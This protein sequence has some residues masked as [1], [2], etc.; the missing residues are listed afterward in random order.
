MVY[1]YP[2]YLHILLHNT[3]RPRRACCPGSRAGIRTEQEWV[4]TGRDGTGRDGMGSDKKGG[5]CVFAYGV[6]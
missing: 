4:G 2:P 3:H 5:C 6:G 1:V